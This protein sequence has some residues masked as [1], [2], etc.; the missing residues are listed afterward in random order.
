MTQD[1]IEYTSDQISVLSDIEHVRLRLQIYLGNTN[2]VTVDVPSLVGN[3]LTIT[4]MS[5]VPAAL[6]AICE[7]I[8]NAIDEFT[9]A[10][11]P[12]ATLEVTYDPISRKISVADNGRGVPI[13]RHVT[14]PYTPEVVFGS[15]R[16][17]RNF[18]SN[19]A[20][21]VRGMNGVGSSVTNFTSSVFNVTVQ[22]DGKIYHQQFGDGSNLRS[23]PTITKTSSK[24]TGTKVEFILD[25]SVYKNPEVPEEVILSVLQGVALCNPGVTVTYQNVVT[26]QNHKFVYAHGFEDVLKK[27]APNYTS[28]K[29]GDLEF[30]VI[31]DFHTDLDERVITWINSGLLFDGGLCNTQFTNAFCDAAVK[32]LAPLAKKQ[33]CDVTKND[34][35]QGLLI[36]GN[37]KVSDPEFDSQSKTRMTG[38]NLRN[39]LQQL[40]SDQWGAFA[41]RNKQWMEAVVQRAA[42]RHHGH[43]TKKAEK[44]LAKKANKKVPGLLDAVNNDRS[45]CTVIVTEGLSAASMIEEVRDPKTLGSFPLTGKLNN[46]WGCKP[47]E[48]M[49]MS[50][51]TNL[52]AA[53]KLIPG[54]KAIRDQLHFSELVIA[55]DADPDGDAIFCLVVALVY[56]FW[57]EL[58][59]PNQKPFV[60]RLVAPN[61]C[62]VK[63]KKRVHF[64]RRA[65][66]EA[67]KDQYKG[68]EVQ[69]YKGLASMSAAD[70]TLVLTNPECRVPIFDDGAVNDILELIFGKG[71][72]RRKVWLQGDDSSLSDS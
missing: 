22:R 71:A 13:D 2:E 40:V 30:F 70:W 63:G 34:V 58:F 56:N 8:D 35:R 62:C 44:E 41:R 51:L 11:T 52:L 20:A 48:L 24:K 3:K 46:V 29:A 66:Y 17:G 27:V 72:D 68:W 36:V 55:S 33:R 65:D 1:A 23:E 9:N 38:P 57:P 49:S 12:K 64:T 43:A 19:K 67:V 45:K 39:E 4:P 26:K 14:G 61:V 53:I 25:G 32:A 60:Y 31:P 69:Y 37:I 10:K 5:Y 50:K 18:T 54:K 16:S 21:G 47:G 6:R 15:L 7:I 42:E 59:D 28:F